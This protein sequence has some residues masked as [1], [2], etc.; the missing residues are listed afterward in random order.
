MTHNSIKNRAWLLPALFLLV[1]ADIIPVFA[2]DKSTDTVRIGLL[3]PDS[4][5][6]AAE[7]GAALA[8]DMA[9]REISRG[10]YIFKLIIK[11]M[12]GPWGTG[13]KQAVDLVFDENVTA[14]LGSHDGRNA[15]LVEQV[16]AKSRVVFVSAWSADPTLAQAFVPWFYNCAPDDNRQAE[17]LTREICSIQNFKKPVVITDDSYEAKSSLKCFQAQAGCQATHQCL[18]INYQENKQSLKEICDR[19][20]SSGTDCIVLFLKPG[21][22]LSLTRVVMESKPDIPVYCSLCQ[23]NEDILTNEELTGSPEIKFVCTADLSTGLGKK[24]V[25]SFNTAYG[26]YPGAVSAYAFDGMNIL[27]GAIRKG[28]LER[29]DI[30]TA[31]KSMSYN[32]VTGLIR[33]DDKG[34]RVGKPGFVI[35]KNGLPVRL[36]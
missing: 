22:A 10:S 21:A 6:V 36:K 7:R 3:V 11:N 32:G 34:N 5:S 15:H 25:E 24:F 16:A 30:Q 13:S 14:L 4:K 18:I 8:V 23:L 20:K 28:G 12:E 2:A 17:A 9:N 19:I 27:I 35:I 29:E 33:F 1:F 26:A 31:M